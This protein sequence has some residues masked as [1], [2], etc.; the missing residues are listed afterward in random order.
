[1]RRQ[2]NFNISCF[3]ENNRWI[4]T[5]SNC[6]YGNNHGDTWLFPYMQLKSDLRFFLLN[7]RLGFLLRR[8]FLLRILLL[9]IVAQSLPVDFFL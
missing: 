1:M 7:F 5:I 2:F 3:G 9:I 4:R 8:I 6:M